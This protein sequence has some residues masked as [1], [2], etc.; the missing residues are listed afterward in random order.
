MT[1]PKAPAKKASTKEKVIII[2]GIIFMVAGVI[3]VL[4]GFLGGFEGAARVLVFLAAGMLLVGP[5]ILTRFQVL[6]MNKPEAYRDP[7]NG[8]IGNDLL[9]TGLGLVFVIPFLFISTSGELL[10]LGSILPAAG[11][12]F[13]SI[14]FPTI[15][16]RKVLD[17]SKP[18]TADT[19]AAKKPADTEGENQ[20]TDADPKN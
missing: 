5:G 9:V 8:E 12:A 6:K 19:E 10:P 17:E 15:R 11:L 4:F 3:V 14:V 20:P 16:P 2:I 7:T 13:L 1:T 18:A